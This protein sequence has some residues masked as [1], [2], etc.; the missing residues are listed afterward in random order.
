MDTGSY[1]HWGDARRNGRRPRRDGTM[2][3]QEERAWYESRWGGRF[4]EAVIFVGVVVVVVADLVRALT[5]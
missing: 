2:N 5:G 3:Q 1:G 4:W